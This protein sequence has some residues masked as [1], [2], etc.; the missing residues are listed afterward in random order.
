MTIYLSVVT[1]IGTTSIEDATL[2]FFNEM[3]QTSESAFLM[4]FKLHSYVSCH[5][6]YKW[7]ESH[8]EYT[9]KLVKKSEKTDY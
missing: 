3:N 2:H 6:L 9:L 4:N 7:N 1:G 8:N 5:F